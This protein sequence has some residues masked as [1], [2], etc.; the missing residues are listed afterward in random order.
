M[1]GK[2]EPFCERCA[3]E[4][5]DQVDRK[6]GFGAIADGTGEIALRA[7]RIEN[8]GAG[9]GRRALAA[10][11][12]HT[13]A[14]HDLLAGARDR[15]L[16]QRHALRGNAPR[17]CGDL[18]R[19]AG[20]HVEYG[21]RRTG[22]RREHA[23]LALDHVLE[24]LGVEHR[25]DDAR[26][27]VRELADRRHCIAANRNQRITARRIDVVARHRKAGAEQAPRQRG[28]DQ[29]QSDQTHIR[30]YAHD[31]T[32]FPRSMAECGL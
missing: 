10:D 25:A 18:V 9:F 12:A 17:E 2:D 21:A 24:L 20:R 5:E 30:F 23:V 6:F 4:A 32:R 28:A 27:A 7:D 8:I 15:H 3:I 1:F 26:A 11:Q 14:L 19:I 22:R 16:E 31:N 13:V 29:P